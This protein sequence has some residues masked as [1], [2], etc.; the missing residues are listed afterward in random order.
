MDLDAKRSDGE[1]PR[2]AAGPFPHADAARLRE[3][4]QLRRA[5]RES[6]LAY[7]RRVDQ[8][9]DVISCN[10]PR[11][12]VAKFLDGLSRDLVGTVRDHTYNLRPNATLRQAYA[13]AW[14]N[15]QSLSMYDLGKRA[16]RTMPHERDRRGGARALQ[17]RLPQVAILYI[18]PAK[19]ACG[20]RLL[21]EAERGTEPWGQTQEAIGGNAQ[22]AADDLEVEGYRRNARGRPSSSHGH[23]EGMAKDESGGK[24]GRTGQV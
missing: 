15:E 4:E 3:F 18:L 12:V 11:I 21:H 16:E 20:R 22:A 7:Y 8:L 9:A 23:S 24:G 1:V 10:E 19:G 14:R 13:I 2:R 5:S 6:L 17:T